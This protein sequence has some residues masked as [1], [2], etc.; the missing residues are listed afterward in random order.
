MKSG[1]ICALK[2][3]GKESARNCALGLLEKAMTRVIIHNSSTNE[4]QSI[5]DNVVR[6]YTA[7]QIEDVVY[8]HYLGRDEYLS[9]IAKIA[10]HLS[11][12][13]RTG[14]VSFTFQ[15]A[16]FDKDHG[17]L[18]VG[19]DDYLTWLVTNA[20]DED[21]FPELY[22]SQEYVS[23]IDRDNFEKQMH[24]EHDALLAGLQEV[25]RTCCDS[26]VCSVN[27]INDT[28]DREL[29]KAGT[30]FE[31]AARSICMTR[32]V[33]S[34]I[35]PV[36][37]IYVPD[38]T[39]V[40]KE[41]RI[42]RVP[43]RDGFQENVVVQNKRGMDDN[44]TTV[45]E[46]TLSKIRQERGSR[47]GLSKASYERNFDVSGQVICFDVNNL[48]SNLAELE[49]GRRLLLPWSGE[50]MKGDIQKDLIEKFRIEIAMRRYFLASL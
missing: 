2:K 44:A 50:L 29:F 7:K 3:P 15:R 36:S 22:L 11:L 25:V 27:E 12:F 41:E 35:P 17:K 6:G 20:R 43:D 47:Y 9:M 46:F 39:P 19:D 16:I 10:L 33:D 18:Y 42:S 23:K 45:N 31:T 38:T 48:I 8:D 24:L 1:S 5:D 34:W 28:Y 30:P 14:R 26:K 40:P 37:E 32:K 4:D 21:I 13:T 49:P